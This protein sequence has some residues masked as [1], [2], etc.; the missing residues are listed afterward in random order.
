MAEEY[1]PTYQIQDFDA[2]RQKECYF[3]I[4]SFAAHLK[5][6][7]FIQKPHKHNFFIVLIITQGTGIHTVDFKEYQVEP[8]TVFFMAPGQVHSWQ[9]S[10]DTDGFI[11]FFTPEF[12]LLTYPH[13]KLFSFPFFNG[14]L[15]SPVLTFGIPERDLLL[16]LVGSMQH[17]FIQQQL[18]KEDVLR[19]YL[20]ILL[21]SLTRMYRLH[22]KEEFF[23]VSSL[24]QLQ[25]LENLIDRYYKEHK[26]VSFYA[27]ELNLTAKQLNEISKRSTGKTPTELI[28][29][30]LVLEAQ[31][32]LVHSDLTVSQV[33]MELGYF[34]NAYFFRFFKKHVGKTPEQFRNTHS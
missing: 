28:Q 21:I 10:D 8:N 32:L 26:P 31:R 20:D 6:H 2:R 29:E 14:L 13:K 5:A 33:A 30:R 17:E 34:D 11:L 22:Y 3:Y 18:L 16:G 19:D 24:S 4:S 7:K 1:L 23:A 15:H 12:Y 27:E 9:L 25:L